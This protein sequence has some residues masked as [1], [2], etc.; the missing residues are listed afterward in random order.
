MDNQEM[1]IDMMSEE[2]K[3]IV[4]NHI[5]KYTLTEHIDQ[6]KSYKEIRSWK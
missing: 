2:M 6:K 1:L 5:F 3:T 4:L